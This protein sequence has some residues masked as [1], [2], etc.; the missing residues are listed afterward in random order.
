MNVVNCIFNSPW[1]GNQMS[2]YAFAR[3]YAEQ[4]GAELRTVP[5]RC[6]RMF[7]IDD[8]PIVEDLPICA[9]V[10]LEKWAGQTNI[11]IQGYA[12]NQSCLIY[13]R[14]DARRFYQFRPNIK[15]LLAQ[16]QV[17]PVCAHLRH[18][19][20][21]GVPGFTAIHPDSYRQ[22]AV[23]FGVNPDEIHF[24]SQENPTKVAALDALDLHF[25]PDWFQLLS[26]K[27]LFRA[28]STFSWWAAVLGDAERIFAPVVDGIPG[29]DGTLRHAPF[30][31]GNHPKLNAYHW[32]CTDLHLSP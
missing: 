18:G 25:L 31:E 23:R 9:D 2:T 7:E 20:Y 5:W 6:Q 21:L 16:I 32:F 3:A 29:S 28:P 8:P 27:I 30:V 10:E 26:A 17:F 19:D 14:R 22:A 1:L 11:T 13:T 12:Q 15:E 4:H 24:V